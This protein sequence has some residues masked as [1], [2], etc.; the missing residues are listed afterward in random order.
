MSRVYT[1]EFENV[2]ITA[3]NG[4]VDLFELRPADDKPIKVIAMFLGQHTEIAD[5]EEEQLR[6]RVIRGNTVSGSGGTTPTPIALVP[7]DAT[8]GFGADAVNPTIATSGT[9]VVLHSDTWNVRIPSNP[10][11][12]PEMYWHTNETAGFIVVRLMQAVGDDIDMSG[13][14]YVEEQ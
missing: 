7:S 1:V 9:E 13:T 14:I 10:P 12:T 11:L 5:A 4:D 2:T 6:L 3:A 8:A